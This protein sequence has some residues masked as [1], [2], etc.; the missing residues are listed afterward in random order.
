MDE[1]L[2]SDLQT[3][4]DTRR[5]AA[6]YKLGKSGNPDVVAHLIMA[7]NDPDSIVRRNVING[8]R[9]IGTVDAM[10]FVNSSEAEKQRIFQQVEETGSMPDGEQLALLRPLLEPAPEAI[11]HLDRAMEMLR[12]A[13][14]DELTD[15]LI[16]DVA[17]ELTL[18]I[19]KANAPFPRAHA[20][21]AMLLNQLGD[22]QRAGYHANIA[23]QQ[24]PNEFRA[25]LV[26]LDVE[27]KG[28]R[29]VNLQAG[30]F[31][32]LDGTWEEAFAG[33]VIKSFASITAASHAGITQAKFRS[34]IDRLTSI[35]KNL[36]KTGIEVDEYLFMADTM[37]GLGDFARGLPFSS[38]YLD[39][40]AAV[41]NTPVDELDLS[42]REEDVAAVRRKAEGRSLLFK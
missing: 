3:G 33:S 17:S 7:Y 5:R 38:G 8:L 6:V 10:Q 35:F 14:E 26:R 11:E 25:Q 36:C 27:L 13:E 4:T 1:R 21:L 28:V 42:G 23:L 18:A 20:S 12:A 15:T 39:L 2:L 34:E 16:L 31:V 41:V 30:D 32:T 9:N 40:Y 29:F 24:D 19:H 37:I 22:D